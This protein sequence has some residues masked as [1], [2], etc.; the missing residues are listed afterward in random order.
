M[1]D[2]LAQAN[3]TAYFV[4]ASGLSMAGL[5]VWIVN[6]QVKKLINH[7]D[8]S[9]VHVNPQNGYVQQSRCEERVKGMKESIDHQ[10]EDIVRIHR[11]IDVLGQSQTENTQKILE[12]IAKK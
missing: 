6:R 10:R 3:N 4:G 5:I 2:M 12:A 11:R 7:A 9:S 1:I 8:N